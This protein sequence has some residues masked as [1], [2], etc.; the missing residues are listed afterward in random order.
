[1]AICRNH[2]PKVLST[3][4]VLT[5]RKYPYFLNLCLAVH[6]QKFYNPRGT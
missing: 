4:S 5:H 1:M 2:P 6:T 3:A